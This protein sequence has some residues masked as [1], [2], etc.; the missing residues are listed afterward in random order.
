MQGQL[1][2]MKRS[3]EQSTEQMW[4]AVG[5]IN[6]EARTM[7]LSRKSSERAM[8]EEVRKMQLQVDQIQ[9]SADYA[10]QALAD[11]REA[12]R[13]EERPWVGI[14]SA[15]PIDFIPNPENHTVNMTVAFT[16]KNYGRSVAQHIHFLAVLN[17]DPTVFNL[18]CEQ[19]AIQNH[20]GDVLLPTQE[21]TMNWALNLTPEQMAAGWTHQ[22]QALGHILFLNILGCIQYAEKGDERQP[23]QTPFTYLVSRKGNFIVPDQAVPADELFISPMGT[24]SNQTQ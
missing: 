4:S 18:S 3:G 5:N 22:N 7:D 14:E 19:S 21:R 23:Y 6:W 11:N 13:L 8:E 2:E 17:S 24:E 12:T 20:A 10:K 15:V 1:D 9:R 16:F